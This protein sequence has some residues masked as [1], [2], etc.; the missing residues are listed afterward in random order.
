MP[1]TVLRA[2]AREGSTFY[3]TVDFKD[4]NGA[5]LTPDTATWTLLDGSGAV[6]NSRQDVAIASPESQE[7][8]VLGA[9]DLVCSGPMDHDVRILLFEF[10]YDSGKTGTWEIAFLVKDL[11]G[12]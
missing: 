7:V 1:P 4:A 5:A 9:A 12:M 8:I 6:V 11:V 10:T 2:V 3:V